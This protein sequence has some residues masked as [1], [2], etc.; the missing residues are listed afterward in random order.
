MFLVLQQIEGN[1]IYP[2]VV[3]S[4]VGLPGIWVLVSVTVGG[5]LFGVTGMIIFIPLASVTYALVRHYVYNQLIKKNLTDA[6]IEEIA[7]N[8]EIN[9]DNLVM[10]PGEKN[11]DKVKSDDESDNKA[12]S[13]EAEEA[14]NADADDEA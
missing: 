13:D 8:N 2:K 10:R 11:K 14:D 3:G 1:L 6:D 4:S 9:M 12:D 7:F 5:S